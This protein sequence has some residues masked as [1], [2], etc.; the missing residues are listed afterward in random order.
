MKNSLAVKDQLRLSVH[1]DYEFLS[2]PH[3][4]SRAIPNVNRERT[5][6]ATTTVIASHGITERFSLT[7]ALPLPFSNQRKGTVART[8]RQPV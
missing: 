8:E 6:N 5:D 1:Y 7:L 2:D 4:G 3:Y